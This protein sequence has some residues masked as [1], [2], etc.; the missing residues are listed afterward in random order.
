M[1][2]QEDGPPAVSPAHRES[3]GFVHRLQQQ[4][5]RNRRGA[6]VG[7]V[8]RLPPEAGESRNLPGP[9]PSPWPEN[10][11]RPCGC[12]AGRCLAFLSGHAAPEMEA[13]LP[14]GLQRALGL[15]GHLLGVWLDFMVLAV[16]M[17]CR[18]GQ[19]PGPPAERPHP[20][21]GGWRLL[22]RACNNSRKTKQ[23]LLP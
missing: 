12:Q 4:Q 10:T 22:C 13:S 21:A 14:R 17:I 6:E 7:G 5:S 8:G 3:C 2:P 11:W 16:W 9:E 23:S 20:A 18:G 1:I 15:R 19:L